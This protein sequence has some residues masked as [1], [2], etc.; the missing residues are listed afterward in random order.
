MQI[1]KIDLVR[2][3][4]VYHTMW[5]DRRFEGATVV[6]VQGDHPELGFTVLVETQGDAVMVSERE[7]LVH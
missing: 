5:I 3:E 4:A 7:T 2:L 1:R 6:V